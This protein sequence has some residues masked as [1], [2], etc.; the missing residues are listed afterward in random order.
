MGCSKGPSFAPRFRSHTR[1]AS[2]RTNFL[3]RFL[4]TE[5]VHEQQLRDVPVPVLLPLFL[6]RR[7]DHRTLSGDHGALLGSGLA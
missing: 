5:H 3:R 1:Q 2:A 6:N 4:L 7:S